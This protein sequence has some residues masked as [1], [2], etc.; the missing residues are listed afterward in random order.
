MCECLFGSLSAHRLILSMTS[1]GWALMF[2]LAQLHLQL[3]ISSTHH[4]YGGKRTNLPAAPFLCHPNQAE[5]LL[6]LKKSFS[7]GTS[8]ISRLLSWRHDTDCCLWEGVGC[9][10]STGNVTVLDLN[11]RGLSSNGLD[12]SIFSLT[13]LRRLDL[14]MSNFAGYRPDNSMWSDNIHALGFER[15]ALLTHLNLSMSGLHG[16]IPLGISKL[17]NLISLDLSSSVDYN[18]DYLG[19]T[20][21]RKSLGRFEYPQKSNFNTLLANLSNLREL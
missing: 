11:N 19:I 2:F 5:A 17:V 1:I 7:F 3:A 21:I 8:T 15:L 20:G 12:P 10:K 4:D 9:D 16:Q 6:Q 14:S 18:Y 13:S